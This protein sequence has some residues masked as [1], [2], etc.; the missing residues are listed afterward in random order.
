MKLTQRNYHSRKANLEYMSCSQFK[1]FTACQAAALAE[2]K[3]KYKREKTTALLVGSFVDA[4]FEGTLPKFIKQN[5]EIFKKD[6]TLKADYLQAEVI[7][8]RILKDKLFMKYLSGQKQVIMTGTI[9]GI[10]VKIKI[11]SLLPDKIVDLKIMRDFENVHHPENGLCP[12][13]EA[14][15]YDLQGAVYQEIVRQN[16]GVKLPF[17]LA[18]ATKEKITDIDIVHISQKMLDFALER[19]ETDAPMFDAIKK[20]IIEPERCNVCAHCKATKVLTEPTETDDFY[21]M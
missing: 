17:Y 7:I 5:P 1:A 10:P 19:F 13:F 21:L 2:I 20:G 18:A 14:W 6:G 12:W 4:Y 15:G 3:G 11:D 8:Q 16:L 9:A